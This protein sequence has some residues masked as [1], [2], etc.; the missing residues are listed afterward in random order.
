M[1]SMIPTCTHHVDYKTIFCDF[2]TCLLWYL[3]VLIMLTI[4][5]S[6]VTS[7]HVFYDTYLYLS[8]WLLDNLLW[9]PEICSMI[10]TCTHHVDYKTIFCDFLTCVLW[11]IPLL[12][13]LTIRQSSVTSWAMFYTTYLYSSCDYK[14][15]F[16][17]FLTYV[18]WYIP[19]LI[20][21]TIRQSSVTSWHVFYDTY[22][23]LSCW[24]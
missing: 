14:T 18:L 1:C 17:D 20:M 11:Y 10:P 7:W 3:P 5:Q 22:L 4:R 6:P 16:C 24:L 13:T 15:I 9:L 21:L 8:R 12:I 2:L 19:V 23:Y